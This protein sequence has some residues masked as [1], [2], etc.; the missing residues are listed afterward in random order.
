M[1]GLL[2]YAGRNQRRQP[3]PKTQLRGLSGGLNP[4]DCPSAPKAAHNAALQDTGA[5]TNKPISENLKPK[6]ENSL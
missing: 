4:L 3:Q 2:A 6:T 1:V 5:K